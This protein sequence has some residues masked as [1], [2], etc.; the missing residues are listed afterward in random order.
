MREATQHT[1][2]RVLVNDRTDIALAARVDGVHLPARAPDAARVRAIAPDGFLIGRS[3]HDLAEAELAQDSGGCDYVTFGTVF[4]ST[5]KPAGHPVAGIEGLG[6]V[7]A[8]TRIPVLAIGGIT[9]ERAAAAAR[10]GAAGIAAIGLF[11]DP[12]RQLPRSD[13]EA[14]QERLEDIVKALRRTFDHQSPVS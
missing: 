6:I 11:A 2:T 1:G 10:A 5:S 9:V 8:R 4:P 14:V 13:L 12:I 3:V 7:C